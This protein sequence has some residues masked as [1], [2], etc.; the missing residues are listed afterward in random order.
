MI[1]KI[2]HRKWPGKWKL[3]KSC[4]GGVTNWL[5]TSRFLGQL[6][7]KQILM[8]FH[9]DSI[10]GESIEG[11]PDKYLHGLQGSNNAYKIFAIKY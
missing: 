8:L 9:N 7:N 10:M 4:R 6:F 11:A 3:S 1:E 5:L 2:N